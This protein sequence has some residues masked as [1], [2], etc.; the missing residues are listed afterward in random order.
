MSTWLITG[1]NR[2]IGLGLASLVLKRGDHVFAGVRQPGRAESL[3]AQ[4]DLH[5]DRLTILGLD[6]SDKA[7]VA[8][9]AAAV[10]GP[11]D[12][13]VNNAGIYGPRSG[14]SPGQDALDMDFD[15][16]A[17]VLAVNTLGPLRVSQAFLPQIEA[18]KGKIIT[19]TSRMGSLAGS[20]AGAVAYRASKAAVN[21]VML[22]LADAL[23]PRGIPV[24][25][26]HPGWVRTDM[27]G[28]EA[29]I[30]VGDSVAGIAALAGQLDMSL[31]AQFRNHDGTPIAW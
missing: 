16:F 8:A 5:G 30:S 17:E 10:T 6:V 12:V 18:A 13:L 15:A 29:D 3:A 1:A 7:S 31:S 28:G 22:G 2:G 9:A 27:G 20:H 24:L 4:K 25:L 21:K 19:I 14:Q 26:V 11:V 23:R